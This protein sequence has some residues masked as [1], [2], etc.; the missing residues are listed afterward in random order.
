MGR[1]PHGADLLDWITSFCVEKNITLGTISLIG[2]VSQ[3]AY[4]YYDQADKKYHTIGPVEREL[5][6]LSA[7]GSISLKDGAPFAHIHI[8]FSDE[9]GD[10]F[11]GHLVTGTTIFACEFNITKLSGPALERDYDETTGLYLWKED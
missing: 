7:T 2:A 5:E 4:S 1:V 11:G 10:A 8:I 6:I 3:A 9:K